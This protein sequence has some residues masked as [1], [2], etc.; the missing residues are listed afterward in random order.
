MLSIADEAIETQALRLRVE[1]LEAEL[2]AS[3]QREQQSVE[4]ENRSSERAERYYCELDYRNRVGHVHFSNLNSSQKWTM[5]AV[6]DVF[7]ELRADPYNVE[8]VVHLSDIAERIGVS[9]AT[10]RSNLNYFK[11]HAP[12]VLEYRWE[13]KKQYDQAGRVII[14]RDKRPVFRTTSYVTMK[15]L[16]EFPESIVPDQLRKPGG[17]HPKCKVCGSEDLEV[18]TRV[19]C[20][21][22]NN[23]EWDW[24]VD[25]DMGEAPP[26]QESLSLVPTPEPVETPVQAAAPVLVPTPAPTSATQDAPDNASAIE[27]IVTV[28]E[29][30]GVKH[31]PNMTCH[32]GSQL[33][34]KS[35]GEWNC[36]R[37]EPGNLW[38]DNYVAAIK[39]IYPGKKGARHEN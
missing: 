19:R 21:N 20:R 23:I 17:Y 8:M 37:C 32:C 30:Y 39:A 11:D 33:F 25:S 7:K 2:S 34:W 29:R 1:Q 10:V 16:I 15:P 38:P 12:D 36:C 4:R 18:V 6:R 13:K 24:P 26:A 22:C 3:L 35:L 31:L 9:E 28:M 27:T 14:G 5:I